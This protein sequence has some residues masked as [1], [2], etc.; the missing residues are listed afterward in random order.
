M[1]ETSAVSRCAQGGRRRDVGTFDR[2]ARLYDL[3]MPDAE[4]D[5]L[6]TGL[7]YGDGDIHHVLDVGGGTGRAAR[8]LAE[9]VRRS[10]APSS[11]GR[12][13]P[14]PAGTDEAARVERPRPLVVD[15]AL[16]MLR[17]ARAAGVEGVQGDAGTLPVRDGAVDAVV[18][19]DALHHFPAA[20]RAIAD[21][22]R[23]LRPGG[24]LVIR[25]FDRTTLRG[26]ALGAVERAVGFD[27]TFYAATDLL[28]LVEDAGLASFLPDRGFGYTV[29]GV[30]RGD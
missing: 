5:V 21:A 23:V 2:L 27:S 11:P 14:S 26:R 19:V 20:E 12:S 9:A 25:E 18:I 15:A 29:V 24:V 10:Q 1:A 6:A 28:D 22:A 3:A 13:R 16:G 4:P 7:A 8:V 17:R 30:K